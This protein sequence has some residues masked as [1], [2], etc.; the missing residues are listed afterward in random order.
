[1]RLLKCIAPIGSATLL[2]CSTARAEP[3]SGAEL[4]LGPHLARAIDDGEAP[5][6]PEGRPKPPPLHIDYASYGVA[7]TA[8]VLAAPGATC[9]DPAVPCI[10]GSGG[11]L[12]MRGGYRAPGP[13]YVGG[14]YQFSKTD[15]DNLYRLAILQQLRAEARYLLDMG[16]RTR[17]YA[18]FGLGGVIYGNEWG[19]ETGGG[20]IL[21]GI[22]FELEV[23]RLAL[24]GM[25]VCYQ[26]MVFAPFRDTAEFERPAGVA[27]Y[28]RLEIQFEMRSEL[29]RF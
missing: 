20:T 10:L 4:A 18:V 24:V 6:Q 1:V 25:A 26:P 17:P 8:D 3:V 22:G 7:V 15:S 12:V 2:V 23:S 27:H 21:A 13:W 29:S 5:R 14:A 16:Y 28:V 11:G 9:A 19:A